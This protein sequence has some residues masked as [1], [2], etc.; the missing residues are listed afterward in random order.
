MKY[1]LGSS[2]GYESAF[3]G[4]PLSF[5][6]FSFLGFLEVL[7]GEAGVT[8]NERQAPPLAFI[9]PAQFRASRD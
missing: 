1:F 5:F 6:L 9:A 7:L 8:A 3:V 2:G 4:V